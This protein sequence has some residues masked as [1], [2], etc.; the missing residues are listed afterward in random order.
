[1]AK[2]FLRQITT[3][4]VPLAACLTACRQAYTP[5]AITNPNHYLVVDGFIN[6]SP[7]SVTTFNLN[8][9]RNLG[10]TTVQ[11][12][13]ELDAT[14]SIVGSGG[15]TWPLTEI[16][17]T[18]IYASASLTLDPTQ[19][20]SISIATTNGEK[21]ASSPVPC[22]VTPPIDSIFWRQPFDLTIY[23]ST[24][25]P[26]NNTRYYRYDYN[27]TWEHDAQLMTAWGVANGMIYAQD[28]TNQTQRC[29]TTDTSASILLASSVAES[30]DV[31]DSFNL[32]TIPNGDPRITKVYSILVRQ[33][34]LTE[35]AYNYWQ[36]IQKTTQD[37]GTLFDI[38]PTQLIGNIT[39]TSNPSEPVI[40]FITATTIQQ[41]RILIAES[42]LNDWEHNQAAFGC[43]T[44]S[45]P[46][47]SPNPLVWNYP[48]PDFA[49]W[50]FI[51]NGPLVL[52]S[53]VCLNC[54]LLGG[55]NMR[56]TFMPD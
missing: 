27:E 47:N 17:G 43:D 10:D 35:D 44:A 9:T 39:C 54:L 31:I 46:Q 12:I 22:K 48:N 26:T 23:A 53:A 52:A 2:Q 5:P 45:I 55:T 51:T 33:Y 6:V 40:G 34:A 25:D 28:S 18:S 49:P 37:V 21:Y 38:Q 7:N 3:L 36:L 19:Q 32:V 4:L 1:M 14:I 20:Y 29:W 8:R 30:S 15:A 13:P 50:Y 11:G 56:P 42:S 24:H 16:G 41:Q